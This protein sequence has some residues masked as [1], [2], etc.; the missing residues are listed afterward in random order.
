MTKTFKGFIRLTANDAYMVAEP[1]EGTSKKNGRANL[2]AKY[3][4][5]VVNAAN[6]LGYNSIDK[7]VEIIVV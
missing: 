1:I 3:N 6:T 7:E 2:A 4:I 5:T